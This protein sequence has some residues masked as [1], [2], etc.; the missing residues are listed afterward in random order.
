[1]PGIAFLANKHAYWYSQSASN[2]LNVQ[3]TYIA[4]SSFDPSD[5]SP[6]KP[7]TVAEIF[8][9]PPS[10]QAQSPYFVPERHENVAGHGCVLSRAPFSAST[11]L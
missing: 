3:Q 4:L 8:L 11:R 6:M 9:G 2:E 10:F 1:M 5:V 7:A